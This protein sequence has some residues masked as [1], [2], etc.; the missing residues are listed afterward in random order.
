MTRNASSAWA[1]HA[2]RSGVGYTPW[3]W[4]MPGREGERQGERERR[5]S[6]STSSRLLLSSYETYRFIS[7]TFGGRIMRKNLMRASVLTPFILCN[8][9]YVSPLLYIFFSAVV[10]LRGL[11]FLSWMVMSKDGALPSGMISSDTFHLYTAAWLFLLSSLL[12]LLRIVDT[13]IMPSMVLGRNVLPWATSIP[14]FSPRLLLLLLIP[15]LE[16]FLLVWTRHIFLPRSLSP[17]HPSLSLGL[18]K[19]MPHVTLL[20]KYIYLF[21]IITVRGEIIEL[22]FE[23]LGFA[24]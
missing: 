14:S 22:S 5:R 24:K 7:Y 11:L 1:G 6:G 18:F 17:S 12:R 8:A 4:S 20:Q 23:W 21:F 3:V 10:Y 13:P 9:V 2:S 16:R 15:F 19:G